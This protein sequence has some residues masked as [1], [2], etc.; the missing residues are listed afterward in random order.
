[1]NVG[2]KW[3]AAARVIGRA[4]DTTEPFEI[5]DPLRSKQTKCRYAVQ[6]KFDWSSKT[7]KSQLFLSLEFILSAFLNKTEVVNPG[8]F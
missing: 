6:K 8:I 7:E 2:V 1:M 3:I 5:Y 4:S